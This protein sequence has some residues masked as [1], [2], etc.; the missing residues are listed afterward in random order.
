MSPPTKFVSPPGSP[1]REIPGFMFGQKGSGSGEGGNVPISERLS[2]MVLSTVGSSSGLGSFE[3]PSPPIHKNETRTPR[4]SANGLPRLD[5]QRGSSSS[6][7]GGGDLGK[8]SPPD[9][10]LAEMLGGSVSLIS[11]TGESESDGEAR[12]R[13][14]SESESESDSESD[15][16]RA[17]G[18]ADKGKGKGK[19]QQNAA[20]KRAPT[21][22]RKKSPVGKINRKN[23]SVSLSLSPTASPISD[24]ETEHGR[25][26]DRIAP[27]PIRQRAPTPSFSVT[28]RPVRTGTTTSTVMTTTTTTM[29]TNKM[30]GVDVGTRQRSTT[31]LPSPT[32]SSS[33]TRLGVL[34]SSAHSSANNKS[35]GGGSGGGSPGGR[36]RSSTMLSGASPGLNTVPFSKPNTKAPN[37]KI[38][39]AP[40]MSSKPTLSSTPSSFKTALPPPRPFANAHKRE[41][42]ASSTGDSS[43]G[44][45]PFT[46]RDGSDVGSGS[47]SGSAGAGA[48]AVI[49]GTGEG[50]RVRRRNVSFE[51]DLPGGRSGGVRGRETP[52][53]RGKNRDVEERRRERR[54]SEAKAAIEVPS[55]LFFD[56]WNILN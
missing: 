22:L 43:S 17:D 7:G 2:R 18:K 36:Q 42:P 48:G 31:M 28:S 33:G 45:A 12:G 5:V 1:E 25:E 8:W 32:S 27:I 29:V 16:G 39:T 13:D 50:R 55:F 51:D 19:E 46:P 24:P 40:A 3:F 11:R 49:R 44:R 53:D 35:D 54:R 23:N 21:K 56:V 41:S 10:V 38:P 52:V 20:S 30:G 4:K 47:L 6:V 34:A 15:Y 9:Q 26:E 14:E 37:A